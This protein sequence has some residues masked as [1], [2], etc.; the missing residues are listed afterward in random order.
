MIRL[1]D[2]KRQYK[3]IRKDVRKAIFG[4]IENTDFIL[5]AELRAFEEEFARFCESKHAVGVDSGT[6]ALELAL[7]AKGIGPGHEV[8]VPVFTF[9]ATA[10]AVATVGA[11]PVFVDVEDDTGNL[12]P[13]KLEAAVTPRTKAVIPVHLFGQPANLSEIAA[14]AQER[15]IALIEDSAQAH[16]AKVRIG[17][18]DWKAAG[19]V[20][21]MGCFS[22]Y[23]GK[24][25]GA[26]GDGGMVVTQSDAH[27]ARLRLLRDYGRTG[28]YEHSILGYNKRLDTLQ[29]AILRVKLKHLDSWNRL[30]R[31][32]GE[33]YDRLLGK[34]GLRTFKTRDYTEPVRHVYAVRVPDRDGLAS[35]LKENG[36]ATGVHYPVPLHMQKAFAAYGYNKGDFPVAEKMAEEILSLPI[37]PELKESEV[38]KIASLVVRYHR[39]GKK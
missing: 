2:L 17:G 14:I 8:I 22:F 3:T 5:G 37:F 1:V 34:A 32:N 38:K 6:G 25:L 19:S 27:A 23:P 24:N 31:R 33:L 28:K 10:S 16:G 39:R 7:H 21:E 15:N 13:E 36:V 9:Y 20:G 30:R 26:Y 4:V 18:S 11:R 35:F 29:A 12:D